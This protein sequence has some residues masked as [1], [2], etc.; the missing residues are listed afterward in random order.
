[1]TIVMIDRYR[2]ARKNQFHPASQHTQGTTTNW[3]SGHPLER[4]R[5]DRHDNAAYLRE[6]TPG[7][8]LRSCP[9]ESNPCPAKN[10]RLRA[11]PCLELLY[12][13][14]L[15]CRR[16]DPCISCCSG[17]RNEYAPRLV[18][19]GQGYASEDL[20]GVEGSVLTEGLARD[21]AEHRTKGISAA[22]GWGAPC[23]VHCCGL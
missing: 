16:Y 17:I 21:R 2:E 23:V 14:V 1:M 15:H 13:D 6:N 19:R 3:S 22:R 20:G 4:I 9:T 5:R 11:T 7:S 8:R 18:G 12:S 10:M